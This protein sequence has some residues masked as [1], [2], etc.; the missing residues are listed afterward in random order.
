MMARHCEHRGTRQPGSAHQHDCNGRIPGHAP[1]WACGIA[2]RITA[3]R[4]GKESTNLQHPVAQ[5]RGQGPGRGTL[6]INSVADT[7]RRPLADRGSPRRTHGNA[8]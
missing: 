6:E 5:R 8:V 4:H 2:W 7:C 3:P 1:R